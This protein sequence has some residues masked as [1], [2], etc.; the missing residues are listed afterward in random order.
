MIAT[1][2]LLFMLIGADLRRAY[3]AQRLSPR[4]LLISLCALSYLLYS[5]GSTTEKLDKMDKSSA[6]YLKSG[7]CLDRV[8][9]RSAS[10]GYLLYGKFLSK[11]EFRSKDD[12]S[13]IYLDALC[14]I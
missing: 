12:V 2:F 3:E 11:S 1:M 4:T 14:A 8:I 13:Q 10:G 9:V 7:A 5:L 6:I